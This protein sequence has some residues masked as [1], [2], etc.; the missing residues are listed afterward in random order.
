MP[1]ILIT[2]TFSSK[3]IFDNIAKKIKTK[4]VKTGVTILNSTCLYIIIDNIVATT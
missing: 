4:P 1:K 3:I 2:V